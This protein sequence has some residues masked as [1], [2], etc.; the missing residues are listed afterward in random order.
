MHALL[1]FYGI[2][3]NEYDVLRIARTDPQKGTSLQGILAVA[4]H[5]QLSAEVKE[6]SLEELKQYL[7]RK[8]PVILLLQAWP[9]KK[10]KD[11]KKHWSD[12]HY[13][14]AIGYD[15]QKIYFEDPYSVLRTFLRY[16]ELGE[17]WHDL[18][19]LNWGS[20]RKEQKRSNLAIIV[21][22]R[23]SKYSSTKA[24]HMD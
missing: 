6:M 20:V 16:K 2:S 9:K 22:G 11:W 4:K 5:F 3:T 19:G 23:K 14:V 18:V 10:I 1:S 8:I 21:Q 15:Q 7:D 24:V 17:R 12:G 13:V